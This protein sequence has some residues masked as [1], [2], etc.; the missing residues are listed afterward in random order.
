[1]NCTVGYTSPFVPPEWISAHGL[2]PRRLQLRR[3]SG[4]V[5][6]GVCPFAAAI[7]ERGQQMG[8]AEA[9]VLTSTC[10]QMRRIIEHMDGNSFRVFLMDVPATWQTTESQ[11]LYVDELHRLG[12][13]MCRLGGRPCEKSRL[14]N[15]MREYDER[16]R[17]E[18]AMR[19]EVNPYGR[20]PLALVGGALRKQDAWLFECID[21]SGGWVAL[22]AT[23]S[24]QRTLPAAFDSARV[25]EDPIGELARAYFGTIPDVFRRPDTLLHEYLHQQIQSRGVRGILLVRYVWCDQWHAQFQRIKEATGLPAIEVDLGDQDQ[26]LQRTRT[27]IESLIGILQ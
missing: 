10:D 8:E 25:N 12:R 13:F 6:A 23:E 21:Q 18:R 14:A 26:D 11:A 9:L 2:V 20:V 19:G 16:R 17:A 3:A 22:D 24:G 4:P 27:R 15:A 7:A 1:M 5:N